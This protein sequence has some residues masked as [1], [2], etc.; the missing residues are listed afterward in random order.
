ML[1]ISCEDGKGREAELTDV[2]VAEFCDT[3]FVVDVHVDLQSHLPLPD[4]R[5]KDPSTPGGF[6]V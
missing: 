4:P 3:V 6:R 5:C 1:G 2:C